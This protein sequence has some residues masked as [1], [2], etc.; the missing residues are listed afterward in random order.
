MVKGY[1]IGSAGHKMVTDVVTV[2]PN[3]TVGQVV[4]NLTKKHKPINMLEYIYVLNSKKKLIGVISVN[5]LFN[6]P[7]QTRI[8]AIMKRNVVEI[9]PGMDQEKVAHIALKHGIRAVPVVKKGRLLGV[10]TAKEIMRILNRSL[11]EDI[12][13]FAGVH[14][15]HLQYENS[16]KVPIHLSIGH[17]IPWLIVGLI[18]IMLTAS[19]IEMF[20]SV[21]NKNIILAFFIPA[22]VYMSS[23]MGT[24]LQTLFVRDISTLGKELKFW[25]YFARQMF[26]ALYLSLIVSGLV[27]TAVATFWGKAHIAAVIA[28][29]MFISS[30]TTSTT[31]LIITYM[32]EK[33]GKDPAIGSGPFATII[34]DMSSVIIY[35]LVAYMLL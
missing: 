30:L 29:S 21:I 5:N 10:V 7:R 33:F 18:G 4:R 13:H 35:F 8:D 15:A 34:S 11:Q 19:F 14:K 27:F 24:Q 12:L 17:R 26:I 16:L 32:I 6:F 22:V 2:K 25:Y 31:A 9:Q 28:I 20:E 3:N 1:N 23:A